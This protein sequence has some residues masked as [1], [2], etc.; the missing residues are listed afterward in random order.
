[1]GILSSTY[2]SNVVALSAFVLAA[3]AAYMGW[4]ARR[5]AAVRVACIQVA[6]GDQRSRYLLVVNEGPSEAHQVTV[7]FE[8]DGELWEPTGGWAA[9]PFPLEVLAA[10][11]VFPLPIHGRAQPGEHAVVKTTWRD[12][13]LG[14]QSRR[15][16]LALTGLPASSGGVTVATL[17]ARQRDALA[18]AGLA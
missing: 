17:Q 1:M 7:Q 6:N 10:G 18:A 4:R 11:D 9:W 16:V 3:W 15:S 5:P 14:R 13:R 8:R 12:R 2:F